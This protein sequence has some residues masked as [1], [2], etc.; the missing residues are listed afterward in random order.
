[1]PAGLDLTLSLDAAYGTVPNG[2]AGSC[3]GRCFA[4]SLAGTRPAGHVDL[5]FVEDIE[6]DAQG[7]AKRWRVHVGGT[8]DDVPRTSPYYRFVETLAHHSIT[9]GCAP[10]AYCPASSATREQMAVFVLVGREGAGYIPPACTTPVFADVPASSPFC[11][12]VEE[13]ARRGAA[14]GCGGENFCPGVPITREQMAVLVLRTLDPLLD[15][16]ACT[17]PMFDDVPASSPYCRWIEELARRGSVMRCAPGSYCPQAPV[18]REQM[19]GFIAGTF[20]LTLYG[21][22]LGHVPLAPAAAPGPRQR[23]RR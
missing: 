18:T 16:P 1:V 19:A 11:P 23:R 3:S 5:R 9:G 10:T 12:W 6:P 8:F 15:P 21:P 22:Q 13:V 2:S 20:E 14:G 17:T 7:Q 4:G